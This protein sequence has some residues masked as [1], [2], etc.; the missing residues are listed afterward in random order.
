[1]T[2]RVRVALVG[3]GLA[4]RSHALDIVI[5]D[6]LELAGTVAA[7]PQSAA[8]MA[9]TFGGAAY[10]SLDAMLDDASIDAAVI[11][12][13]PY[14]A[15]HVLER[16]AETG[17]PCL[18]EKPVATS[19]ESLHV[20]EHLQRN[21]AL[22]IAPFNRRYAPH[23]RQARAAL[24]AGEIGEI[25]SVD[26]A[27]Q[28]PYRQ[29]FDANSGTYRA[30]ASSREGVLL[31]SGTHALDAISLLLGGITDAKAYAA[32]LKC[33]PRGADVE[34]EIWFCAGPVSISLRL[35]DVPQSPACGGWGIQVR[36]T[37]GGLALDD[38]ECAIEHAHGQTQAVHAAELI[39]PASDLRRLSRDD[40][41]LGTGLGEIKDL[42]GIMIAIYGAASAQRT[43]WQRPRSKALG[44]LNGSC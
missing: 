32:A 18:A 34:G 2:R 5:D 3:A 14:A 19:E 42:S 7:T 39:R 43:P 1:M 15:F 44:R 29:R 24:A 10:Q 8:A 38:Q 28:G 41:T 13:P 9:G 20:L 33:N 12:V 4:A 21:G 6:T 37:D 25:L 30:S 23:V 40:E 11:A 27:W 36:G 17:M 35:S 26:A 31:D 22:V 16:V